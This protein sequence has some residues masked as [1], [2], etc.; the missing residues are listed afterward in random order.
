VDN[1]DNLEKQHWDL[2]GQWDSPIAAFHRLEGT[3]LFEETLVLWGGNLMN[4]SRELPPSTAVTIII[5]ANC[6]LAGGGCGGYARA[7]RR[8]W[9]PCV[10]KPV[11]VT[12]CTRPCSIA[13]PDTSG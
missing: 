12:I 2:A 11:P 3:G 4:S 7:Y 1:H 10:E 9:I 13:W 8:V 5:M 6:W